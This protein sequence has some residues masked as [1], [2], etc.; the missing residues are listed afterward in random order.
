MAIIEESMKIVL[1]GDTGVGKTALADRFVKNL[2]EDESITTI[3][4][5]F[6]TKL[7]QVDDRVI[8]VYIW[9]TAGQE[10][11][12]SLARMY[13]NNVAAAILVYDITE[14]KSFKGMEAWY[15]ELEA[16]GPK[17]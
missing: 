13:F 5:T 6:L 4:A 16:K 8:R 17:N 15:Y 9:D 1:L 10:K 14:L 3:G 2:Y 11:Y 12:R 7:I